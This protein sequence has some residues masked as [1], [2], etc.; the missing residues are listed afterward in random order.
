MCFVG[1]LF[2]GAQGATAEEGSRRGGNFSVRRRRARGEPTRR[3]GGA[4]AR[5]PP[6][7]P[8]CNAA[9]GPLG[10][11][12]GREVVGGGRP[13]RPRGGW[14]RVT[15]AEGGR[16]PRGVGKWTRRRPWPSV[17]TGPG[18]RDRGGP[19]GERGT[20]G[21]ESGRARAGS[22]QASRWNPEHGSEEG[23][24]R[25]GNAS[26]RVVRAQGA[27]TAARRGAPHGAEERARRRGKGG[28][29]RAGGGAGGAREGGGGGGGRGVRGVVGRADRRAGWGRGCFGIGDVASQALASARASGPS[30]VVNV[31]YS[32]ASSSGWFCGAAPSSRVPS[33]KRSTRAAVAGSCWA[34]S[35]ARWRR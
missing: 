9:G 24:G 20:A 16:P 11:R 34:C 19:R 10:G 8:T 35:M 12:P 5:T 29:S 33:Q 13:R 14:R 25:E 27:C 6:W 30:V 26:L 17:R 28:S 1:V 3:G 15:G 4:R 18:A 21:N 23:S 2:C 32:A 31:N 7:W 22:A